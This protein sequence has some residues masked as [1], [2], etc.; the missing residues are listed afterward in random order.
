MSYFSSGKNKKRTGGMLLSDLQVQVHYIRENYDDWSNYVVSFNTDVNENT[1]YETVF[2][3]LTGVT[4]NDELVSLNFSPSTE[5]LPLSLGELEEHLHK[6]QNLYPDSWSSAFITVSSDT[7]ESEEQLLFVET[8]EDEKD[9][10]Y[11]VL[12]SYVDEQEEQYVFVC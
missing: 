11:Y 5:T 1:L 8:S 7:N 4:E 10:D 9:Y 6:L 3:T 12:S 2:C